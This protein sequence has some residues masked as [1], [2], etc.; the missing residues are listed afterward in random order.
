MDNLRTNWVGNVNK[1]GAAVRA[2][3]QDSLIENVKRQAVFHAAQRMV[4]QGGK[5]SFIPEGEP[6]GPEEVENFFCRSC[7]TTTTTTMIG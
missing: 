5:Y 3:L 2:G 4:A 7:S 6:A 1:I